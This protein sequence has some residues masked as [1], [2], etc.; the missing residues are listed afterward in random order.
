MLSWLSRRRVFHTVSWKLQNRSFSPDWSAVVEGLRFVR[1]SV[2]L[3]TLNSRGLLF[4]NRIGFRPLS[5]V[6]HD[7][8][9]VV[10]VIWRS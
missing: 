3:E 7:N 4:G 6:L 1:S 8:Q 5:E 10:V 2:E 9:D